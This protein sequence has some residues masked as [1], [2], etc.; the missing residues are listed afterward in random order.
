ME[1]ED[2]TL[3]AIFDQAALGVA[4][5]SLDGSWLRVNSRYCQMLGY[6]E[7]ELR[8]KRICDI[9]HP[10]DSDEVLAGRRQLLEG[11]ISSHSMEKRYIRKDGTVFWGRLKGWNCLLGAA[12]SIAGAGSR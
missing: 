10:D 1:T 9:T 5:I 12:K 8:I 3:Q 7:S 4:Q 6:A 2:K 11:A